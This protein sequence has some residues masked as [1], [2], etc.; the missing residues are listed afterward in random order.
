MEITTVEDGAIYQVHSESGHTYTVRYCGSG[1]GDPEY[2]ALWECDCPA[3]TEAC[4]HITA[5]IDFMDTQDDEAYEA[6]EIDAR[7]AAQGW[8]KDRKN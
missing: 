5:V 6:A 2:T 8:E 4:R 7:L 3:R 1:D